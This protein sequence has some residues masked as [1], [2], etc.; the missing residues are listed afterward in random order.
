MNCSLGFFN[1]I[2]AFKKYHVSNVCG[3]LMKGNKST[4]CLLL[5]NE[6]GDSCDHICLLGYFGWCVEIYFAY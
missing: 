4:K 6:M 5:N 3:E 2:L 1:H